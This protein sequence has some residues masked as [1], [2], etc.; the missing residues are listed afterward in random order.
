MGSKDFLIRKLNELHNKFSNLSIKYQY[1]SHTENHIVEI[2]PLNEFNDNDEYVRF[3]SDLSY[4][5]D[6]LF[7][8]ESIMFVSEESLTQVNNPELVFEPLLTST[9]FNGGYKFIPQCTIKSVTNDFK[10]NE[11][12]PLA[13]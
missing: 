3:E 9:F 13:S 12:F 8:P 2:L 5:F 6:T 10:Q 7:F 4:E 11:N 1:D